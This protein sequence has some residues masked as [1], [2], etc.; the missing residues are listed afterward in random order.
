M[1]LVVVLAPEMGGEDLEVWAWVSERVLERVLE[2]ATEKALALAVL[3]CR[4]RH[5]FDRL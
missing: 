5:C 3:G 2:K 1:E 4:N